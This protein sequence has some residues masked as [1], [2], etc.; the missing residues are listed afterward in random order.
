MDIQAN[1]FVLHMVRN[2]AAGLY[3]VGRAGA[4][5]SLE[6]L[7]AAK[8]RTLLGPTAPP[9]G[10]YLTGVSYPQFHLPDPAPLAWLAD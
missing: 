4:D 5:M 1:A 3:G 6:A 9:H 7:L 10:L 2:I 8:D